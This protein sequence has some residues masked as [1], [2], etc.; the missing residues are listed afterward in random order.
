MDALFSGPAS[1]SAA[2]AAAG[3]DDVDADAG[4]RCMQLDEQAHRAQQI[5]M[6][7]HLMAAA[8]DDDYALM[9]SAPY[10]DGSYAA[11]PQLAQQQS[12]LPPLLDPF[13]YDAPCSPMPPTTHAGHVDEQYGGASLGGML[14]LKH[15]GDALDGLAS[16][17]PGL[18]LEHMFPAGG[19]PLQFVGSMTNAQL[20]RDVSPMAPASQ[21]V[22]AAD[23][24]REPMSPSSS[25]QVTSPLSRV[26]SPHMPLLPGSSPSSSP[27]LGAMAYPHR[28]GSSVADS[29]SGSAGSGAG[30]GANSAAHSC[31]SNS[32][33]SDSDASFDEEPAPKK[34]R[35]SKTGSAKKGQ[36]SRKRKA[37]SN[38]SDNGSSAEGASAATGTGASDAMMADGTVNVT[39]EPPVEN[40]RQ[41]RLQRNRA[42]A[43]LSRE[44]KK[45]YVRLLEKQ[46]A[47][48]AEVNEGLVATVAALTNENTSLKA[49]LASL[50]MRERVQQRYGAN[51]ARMPSSAGYA[52][53]ASSQ[54]S[55][56]DADS[57][58]SNPAS[59]ASAD[60]EL[61]S[62]K[63]L[64]VAAF[65][66]SPQS[67]SSG[68]S[69]SGSRGGGVRAGMLLFTLVMSV[70]LIM[71]SL[72]GGVDV[73]H[74]APPTATFDLTAPAGVNAGPAASMAASAAAV[75]ARVL[76]SRA[77]RVLASVSSNGDAL[78]PTEQDAYALV[79]LA[80]ASSGAASSATIELIDDDSKALDVYSEGEL[81]SAAERRLDATITPTLLGSK[82]SEADVQLLQRLLLSTT[83]NS[84]L[85]AQ[86]P[87]SAPNY[88]FA[89]GSMSISRDTWTELLFKHNL[90]N[91]T[92]DATTGR[93][94]DERQVAFVG[95]AKRTRAGRHKITGAGRLRKVIGLP[96][97]PAPGEQGMSHPDSISIAPG[98]DTSLLLSDLSSLPAVQT[99]LQVGDKLLLWVPLTLSSS[100]GG[101]PNGTVA[102][103][104]AQQGIVE[105]ACSIE[106]V[107][108][109]VL[110]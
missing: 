42:S 20:G 96:A 38:A 109:I 88:L 39:G 36:Q 1:A 19:M 65:S 32:D 45:Q 74:T 13:G 35:G 110:S 102:E 93:A 94:G 11:V 99:G 6:E 22:A 57:L 53:S 55:S 60:A 46:L 3:F 12:Q 44:R 26:S 86:Q 9:D 97:L 72:S 92:E 54:P 59:P 79:P 47:D 4:V 75:F 80:H 95:G 87:S 24:K 43:Q 52:A 37:K 15:D 83:G 76:P 61:P 29:G 49:R 63:R 33:A 62:A 28:S 67:P 48:M 30:S 27:L 104:V 100:A 101:D 68:S 58:G 69:G 106:H 108:P 25:T 41:Q 23:I 78:P 5:K 64:R 90:L 16:P 66:G 91:N 7:Q 14:P 71:N 103:G 77:G 105:I 34:A 85:S 107:R 8:A 51:A 2:A 21:H 31:D 56:S 40:K 84:T 17:Q 50:S 18:G 89:P 81:V 98:A 82:P 70:G 73:S 10:A